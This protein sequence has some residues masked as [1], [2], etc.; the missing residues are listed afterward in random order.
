MEDS[1]N[2][3]DHTH[4][5]M[6]KAYPHEFMV[7]NKPKRDYEE[8]ETGWQYMSD[9]IRATVVVNSVP[10][11]WDAYIWIKKSGLFK[12]ISIKDKLSSDLKNV[13]ITFDFDNKMIGELQ[14]R[15]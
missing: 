13:T 12:V 5:H 14:F 9:M 6:A 4:D 1:G 3:D 15:Y 10:E 8:E 11:L 2:S 7:N